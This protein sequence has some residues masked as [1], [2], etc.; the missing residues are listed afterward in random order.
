ML[1]GI[2]A[3]KRGRRAAAC[4]PDSGGCCPLVERAAGRRTTSGRARPGSAPCGAECRGHPCLL[5]AHPAAVA[6]RAASARRAVRIQ[7]PRDV[8]RARSIVDRSPHGPAER[9]ASS[10]ATP[11]SHSDLYDSGARAHLVPHGVDPERLPSLAEP[12]PASWVSPAR[13]RP[14]RREEG[15]RCADRCRRAHRR[16]H[17]TLRIVGDGP[18]RRLLAAQSSRSGC[19]VRV[20]LVPPR[21]RTPQLPAEYAAA[22]VVIVPSVV[23][24]SGDRDGLPNVVLEAHGERPRRSLAARVGAIGAAVRDGVTG[25]LMPSGS[26]T[27]LADAITCSVAISTIGVARWATARGARRYADYDLDSLCGS[28]RAS[29]EAAYA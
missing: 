21:A 10:P 25:L 23:D 20:T 16:P 14:P 19:P 5:R 8:T 12:V 2:F 9:R 15:L 18:R 29:A 1:A 24:A 6:E 22:D 27:A 28:L 26:P 11:M 3:T 7:C 4:S 17:I 13:G